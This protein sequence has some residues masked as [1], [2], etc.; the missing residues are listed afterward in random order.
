MGRSEIRNGS[1]KVVN[2]WMDKSERRRHLLCGTSTNEPGLWK[3][4]GDKTDFNW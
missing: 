2:I 1:G 3:P 4:G